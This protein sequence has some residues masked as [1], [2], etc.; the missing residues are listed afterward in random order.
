MPGP[1][2]P[3]FCWLALRQTIRFNLRRDA[4][5]LAT[6]PVGRRPVSIELFQSQTRCQAPGDTTTNALSVVGCQVS[7][8]DEMP[9]PGRDASTANWFRRNGFVQMDAK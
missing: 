8:S 1:W 3:C 4:R 2:R 6:L 5:P 7:I 9:G